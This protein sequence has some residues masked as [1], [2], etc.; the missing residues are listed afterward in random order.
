MLFFLAFCHGE[1]HEISTPISQLKPQGSLQSRPKPKIFAKFLVGGL[2]H[3][4]IILGFY[5]FP[6]L[7]NKME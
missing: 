4:W 7:G 6:Y 5:D 1:Y 3:D 2:E